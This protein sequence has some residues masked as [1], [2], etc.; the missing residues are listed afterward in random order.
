MCRRSRPS[1]SGDASTRTRRACWSSSAS[2]VRRA[3]EHLVVLRVRARPAGFDEVDAEPVELLGDAQLVVDGERDA[4]ELRAVAQRRVV[5]LDSCLVARCAARGHVAGARCIVVRHARASPCSFSTSPRIVGE[6]G[7]LDLAGDL[8]RIADLAVV[9][10]ADRHDLGRGA[11]EE[12]LVGEVEVACA[13][14]SAHGPRSR[15]RARSS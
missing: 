6:V 7:L 3:A 8:A 4:L 9:D 14:A 12:R 13:A 11:G 15:S 1:P 10:R 5:D 2:S